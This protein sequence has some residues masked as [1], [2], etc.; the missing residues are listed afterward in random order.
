MGSKHVLCVLLLVAVCAAL[1]FAVY[2]RWT[3]KLYFHCEKGKFCQ[4]KNASPVQLPKAPI[5]CY[6]YYHKNHLHREALERVDRLSA[7]TGCP[8]KV[9]NRTSRLALS[10]VEYDPPAPFAHGQ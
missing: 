1:P 4:L 7:E 3:R 10:P 8:Y 6:D 9:I 2:D 5:V